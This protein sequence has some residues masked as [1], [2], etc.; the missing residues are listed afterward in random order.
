[1]LMMKKK[2]LNLIFLI[3]LVALKFN[4]KPYKL[5]YLVKINKLM[6]LFLVMFIKRKIHDEN[7]N[8]V[9]KTNINIIF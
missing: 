7:Y 2:M 5:K 4:V 8:K 6:K 3:I 1:M 9:P